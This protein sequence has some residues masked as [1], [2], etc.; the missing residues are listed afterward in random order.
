MWLDAQAGFQV[1]FLPA[2]II[3]ICV[4]LCIALLFLGLRKLGNSRL[5]NSVK[6]AILPAIRL[7]LALAIVTYGILLILEYLDSVYPSFFPFYAKPV[8][9]TLL[10]ELVILALAIRAA[11]ET[12][13]RLTVSV[14]EIREGEKALIYAAYTIGL[15]TL[16]YVV[17]SSPISPSVAT[18]TWSI[19][20]FITGLIVTYLA[21]YVANLVMLRYALG[22]GGDQKGLQTTITFVRRLLLAL[23]VLIGVSATTFANFPSAGGAIASLFIAAGFGSIVVGLAAQSSLSNLVA[24]ML[25]SVSQ[26]FKFG[27]AVVF[28]NEFCFV[29]D[30]QLII[31]VLRTWDNRRLMVP[32]Q[33]FLSEV[34][35][36]Y[37][38]R[39]PTM[40][41]PVLVQITYESDLDKAMEIMKAIARN[42]PDCLPIG[43]LPNVVVMDYTESG[44]SL[45]LLSRAKDQPTAFA[46]ERD[47]LYQ[48]KRAFDTSGIEIAYPRRHVVLH[49]PQG[50][51]TSTKT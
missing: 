8:E 27:D 24:G 46:M 48:I 23:I 30:I 2:Y 45:R 16:L 35:T 10:V 32:N 25:I 39:D 11:S 22:M 1:E 18:N 3:V 28:Q 26:P 34:V 47:I 12:I 49:E 19:V 29:E 4:V 51:R 44:I 31:T 36:N 38:A 6:T 42:H 37:T 41:A 5:P 17:L 33:L 13:K 9:L 7:P 40:L 14:P 15:I 50:T 20:N 21:A 43:D